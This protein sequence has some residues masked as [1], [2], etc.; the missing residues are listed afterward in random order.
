MLRPLPLTTW[1]SC[2]RDF[3]ERGDQVGDAD[4]IQVVAVPAIMGLVEGAKRI[5]ALGGLKADL[6]APVISALL[7]IVYVYFRTTGAVVEDVAV[8]IPAVADSLGTVSDTVKSV[9]GTVNMISV[10]AGGTKLGAVASVG[11]KVLRPLFNR[12]F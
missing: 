8:T 6:V 12:L 2:R 11:W 3:T 10:V 5:M 4:L 7:G 9:D 1:G